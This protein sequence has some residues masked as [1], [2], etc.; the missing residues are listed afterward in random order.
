MS[1]EKLKLWK[2]AVGSRKNVDE[3]VVKVVKI[4]SKPFLILNNKIS[5]N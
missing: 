1:D 5:F 3:N 4:V 2:V